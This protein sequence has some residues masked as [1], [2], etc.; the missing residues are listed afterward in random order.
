[1]T[2]NITRRKFVK[3]TACGTAALAASGLALTSTQSRAAEREFF[4][5][6]AEAKKKVN[7]R[8]DKYGHKARE[9]S[10]SGKLKLVSEKICQP[11]QG[12]SIKLDKGQVIR[13]EVIDGPQIIDTLYHVRSRPTE[14]WADPYHSTVMGAITPYEG[15]HYYS[16]TPFTR[17]LLTIIRDTVDGEKIREKYGP[18]GAHSFIYNS[19]RCTSGIYELAYGIA[20]HNSCDMNLKQGLV[21]VMGEEN[22]RLFHTPAA[23][24]HFQVVA[25]DKDP[26]NV[27]YYPN[28]DFFK[29]GDGVELL[30]HEDLYV[31]LSPCPLGDQ[32]DTSDLKKCVNWPFKVSIYE[33]PDGPLDTAPDPGHETK[34]PFGYIKA[35]RPGMTKGVIG[36]PPKH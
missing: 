29:N 32:N 31:I 34:E 11:F 8:Y 15:M 6:G 28:A 22:A 26:L 23:F 17:P 9:L 13:Y 5:V 12:Y 4:D 30:A 33:G 2:E 14:E 3:A 1:M 27:T 21:E 18:T 19:G 7:K 16:N 36:K 24:M 10:D 25:F 35:G 20:N